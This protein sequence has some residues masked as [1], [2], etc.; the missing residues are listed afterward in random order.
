MDNGDGF[1]V[2]GNNGMRMLAMEYTMEYWRCSEVGAKID[3]MNKEEPVQ[4]VFA[5]PLPN[6]STLYILLITLLIVLY[7]G[8]SGTDFSY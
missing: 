4:L 1:I 8:Q 3:G 6:S 5:E 2:E 7:R